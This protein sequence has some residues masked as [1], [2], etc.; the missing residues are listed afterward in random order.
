M[1]TMD[2]QRTAMLGLS[3]AP[4]AKEIAER[5]RFCAKLFLDGCKASNSRGA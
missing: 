1:M 4:T 3:K 5:A 2:L